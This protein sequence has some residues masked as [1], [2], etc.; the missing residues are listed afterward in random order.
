METE[1]LSGTERVCSF[2]GITAT[3]IYTVRQNGFSLVCGGIYQFRSVT[4]RRWGNDLD[5]N[6]I[7]I[8]SGM[9]R[10]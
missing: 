5:R 2:G 10:C 7:I 3:P 9:D 4:T 1:I 6:I 8:A